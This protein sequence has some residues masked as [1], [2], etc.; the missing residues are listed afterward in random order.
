MKRLAYSLFIFVLCSLPFLA[1]G[2]IPFTE[3]CNLDSGRIGLKCEYVGTIDH[4]GKS[5]HYP[6]ID[7]S[8]RMFNTCTI[9]NRWK[10]ITIKNANVSDILKTDAHVFN[11]E[12]NAKAGRSVFDAMVV[13]N[14]ANFSHSDLGRY[15]S[16]KGGTFTG[17]FYLRD[18]V[19]PDTLIL[20]DCNLHGL[21]R[22]LELTSMRQRSSKQTCMLNLYNTDIDKLR[23]DYE[24]FKLIFPTDIPDHERAYIYQQVLVKL[25]AEGLDMDYKKLDVEYKLFY[26]KAFGNWWSHCTTYLSKWWWNFGYDKPFIIIGAFEI[27]LIIFLINL[28]FYQK[29]LYR[30]Y[31]VAEFI[32]ADQRLTAKFGKRRIRWI[33]IPL[34]CLLYTNYIFWGLKLDIEKIKLNNLGLVIWIFAQY[35]IGIFCLAWIA[36]FIITK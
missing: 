25:K 17:D 21:G 23:L 20:Q 8:K 18:I 11:I 36:N 7:L 19:M 35:L 14:S 30:G 24:N 32:A 10:E 16:F 27:M 15:V 33:F 1:A 13:E 9:S 28:C 3:K 22:D 26:D 34:Y 31:A 29:L 6:S 4:N 5:D 2:Q 12:V